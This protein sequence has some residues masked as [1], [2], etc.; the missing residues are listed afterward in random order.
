[1]YLQ[2][3]HEAEGIYCN[4][5]NPIVCTSSEGIYC[6][7][8]NPI[9]CTSTPGPNAEAFT[10]TWPNPSFAPPRRVK[11]S[12]RTQQISQGIA[13]WEDHNLNGPSV[14]HP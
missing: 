3:A 8:A 1:M 14:S 6:N 10:A 2:R 13:T 7:V 9:E 11:Q 12:L 5:A 4:V